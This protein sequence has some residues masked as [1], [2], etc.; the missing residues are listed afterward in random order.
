MQVKVHEV[1][2]TVNERERRLT[3]A[4]A[5]QFPILDGK[6]RWRAAELGQSQ[7]DPIC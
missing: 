1:T 5:K 6:G 4:I 7:P 3:K 2:L